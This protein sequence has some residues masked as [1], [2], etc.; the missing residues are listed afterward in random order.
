MICKIKAIQVAG[1]DSICQEIPSGLRQWTELFADIKKQV[2]KYSPDGKGKCNCVVTLNLT[3]HSG[4]KGAIMLG[5]GQLNPQTK[6]SI[7]NAKKILNKNP[8]NPRALR[9]LKSAEKEVKFLEEVKKLMCRG[10][11]I[12]FAQCQNGGSPETEELLDD[13]FGNDIKII[14][15]DGK[16]VVWFLGKA[17][18]KHPKKKKENET[19]N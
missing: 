14:T 2:G 7:Q 16:N 3:S 9:Y 5:D 11:T 12:D 4:V 18:E 1:S 13:I 19:T 6:K 17:I 15:H 8:D 10:G